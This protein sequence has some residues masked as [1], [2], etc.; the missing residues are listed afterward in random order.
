MAFDDFFEGPRYWVNAN[1]ASEAIGKHAWES[2]C[3]RVGY[4][5]IA[6][7]TNERTLIST[8]LPPSF[9]GNKI[10]TVSPFHA[11]YNPCGP[12]DIEA[13]WLASIFC[14][15]PMDYLIRQKVMETLN[16]FFLYSLSCTPT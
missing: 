1:D 14:S 7:G 10:P 13:L 6:A 2:N 4:R 9:H 5:D 8:I 16:F 12:N 15:Y 3:Y 11:K